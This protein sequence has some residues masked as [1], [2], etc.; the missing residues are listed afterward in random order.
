MEVSGGNKRYYMIR[1]G[2]RVKEEGE[3]ERE[4]FI[5]TEEWIGKGFINDKM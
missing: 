4:P 2:W 5:V 1:G 3:K